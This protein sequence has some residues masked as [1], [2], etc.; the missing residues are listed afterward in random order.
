MQGV[1]WLQVPSPGTSLRIGQVS[2]GTTAVCVVTHVK[3]IPFR[4]GVNGE[5]VRISEALSSG[6]G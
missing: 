3:Q 2:V 1:N 6:G 5:G 4:K